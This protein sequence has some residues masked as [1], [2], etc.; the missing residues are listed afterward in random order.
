MRWCVKTW[1]CARDWKARQSE[2]HSPLAVA[3]TGTGPIRRTRA[4]HDPARRHHGSSHL[5][6][7]RLAEVAAIEATNT[8]LAGAAI[9]TRGHAM[10]DFK[11]DD[12]VTWK[13]FEEL[14]GLIGDDV[15]KLKKQHEEF[16]AAIRDLRND[17][18][19]TLAALAVVLERLARRLPKR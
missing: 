10:P 14:A 8:K 1:N 7:R 9:P 13:H 3:A 19:T 11:P 5:R 2:T 15:I 6:H 17:H 16:A 18:T 4:L 12:P